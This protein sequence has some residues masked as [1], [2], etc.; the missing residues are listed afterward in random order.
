MSAKAAHRFVVLGVGAMG[1]VVVGDLASSSHVHQITIADLNEGRVKALAKKLAKKKV[2]ARVVNVDDEKSLVKLLQG[3]H[4]VINCTPYRKNVAVMEAALRAGAHYLD[5]G[6]LYHETR[7]QLKLHTKFR[8]AGLLAILGIGGSPGITNVMTRYAA[9]RLDRIKEIQIRVASVL[10]GEAGNPL[11]LPYSLATILEELTKPP[12]LYTKGRFANVEPL[13]G[14]ERIVFPE[15]LGAVEA[16]YT[17][18]SELATLPV[19]FREKGIREVS[20]KVAFPALF[21]QRLRLLIDLGFAGAESIE[22]NGTRIVPRDYLSQL[23]A[24]LP[25][26]EKPPASYGV[27]RV[28]VHGKKGRQHRKYELDL[29]RGPRPEYP[30]VNPT[31]I[32]TGLPPSIV[33]QMMASGRIQARGVLPPEACVEPEPFFLELEKRGLKVTVRHEQPVE[34]S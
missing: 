23:V 18:H 7:R 17:L 27:L 25:R 34:Q 20:F 5:L 4:V 26:Q 31:A 3:H 12:V 33:G 6:G 32:T 1:P 15:P 10:P 2:K 24:N 21:F 14:Q 19:S 11:S 13:S 30:D 29:F 9:E 16:I 22:V 8:K 28:E